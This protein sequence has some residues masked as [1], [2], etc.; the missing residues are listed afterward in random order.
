V[1]STSRLFGVKNA[2]SLTVSALR[3]RATALGATVEKDRGGDERTVC[4]LVIAPEGKA[5]K[6]GPTCLR[7]EWGKGASPSSEIAAALADMEAGLVPG[8][9]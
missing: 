2:P 7:V 5:W 6:A 9:G 1:N 8:E 4:Y 3:N